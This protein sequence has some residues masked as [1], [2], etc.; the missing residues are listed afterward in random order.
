MN[1]AI[2]STIQSLTEKVSA[3]EM[4]QM[5]DSLDDQG[6]GLV[7]YFTALDYAE[8]VELIH[9]HGANV[10]LKAHGTNITPLVIAATRGH[11]KT[12]R[13]LM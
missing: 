5:L 3:T 7:H 1:T 13:V 2:K 10:N 12:V 9:K 4:A 11:E 6:I 8:G